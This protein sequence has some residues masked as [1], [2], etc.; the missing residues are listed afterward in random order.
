MNVTREEL[1][2]L[3]IENEKLIHWCIHN[4]GVSITRSDYEDLK[5]IA[6]EAMIESI[7]KFDPNKGTKL[8]TYAIVYMLGRLKQFRRTNIMNDGFSKDALDI[9]T[10]IQKSYKHYENNID[11]KNFANNYMNDLPI[12]NNKKNEVFNLIDGFIRLDKPINENDISNDIKEFIVSNSNTENDL[13]YKTLIREFL[14]SCNT[15]KEKDIMYKHIFLNKTQKELSKEYNVSHSYISYLLQRAKFI[16][17]NMFIN[18]EE[19]DNA[20]IALFSNLSDRYIKNIDDF[21]YYCEKNKININ[22]IPKHK[23]NIYLNKHF[24]LNKE[25][26]N[27]MTTQLYS[28]KKK[29]RLILRLFM[30]RILNC[31]INNVYATLNASTIKNFKLHLKKILSK[32]KY[33]C[34]EINDYIDKLTL[35]QSISIFDRALKLIEKYKFVSPYQI[36][37]NCEKFTNDSLHSG[38]K[39]NKYNINDIQTTPTYWDQIYDCLNVFKTN[40]LK[41]LGL[42]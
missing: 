28:T 8:S 25:K 6:I 16:C 38:E 15:C 20:L 17:I 41:L 2:N 29:N 35:S 1:T 12:D 5:Q 9:Y 40:N 24:K 27:V 34:N 4:S 21:Y 33:E 11:L 3:L 14:D 26:E 31:K 42:L 19:Y 10:N 22:K 32:T 23:L 7:H 39:I 13:L 30:Y 36:G 18:N 37:I